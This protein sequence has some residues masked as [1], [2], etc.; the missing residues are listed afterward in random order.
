MVKSVCTKKYSCSMLL[1]I[2]DS[3]EFSFKS[4]NPS[5][6]SIIDVNVTTGVNVITS[7]NFFISF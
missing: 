6:I 3:L 4:T 1:L 7:H 2:S 5:N